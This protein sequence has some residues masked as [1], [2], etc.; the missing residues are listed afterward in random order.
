MKLH[1][2]PFL[3]REK[4]S[5]L[6]MPRV[7]QFDD[8]LRDNGRSLAMRRKVI[9]K[10]KTLLTFAQGRGLVAQ[11]VAREVKVRS[12]E[13]NQTTGP[14]RKGVDFPSRGELKTL[15]GAAPGRWRPF[16]LCAAFT[17]MRASELRGLPWSNVD[18]D[19]GLIHIRQRADAWG[20]IGKPKSKA[21]NR[22]IP[23]APML[24]NALRQWRD[25]CPVGQHGLVFPN[26]EGNVE[27]HSNVVHRFWHPLQVKNGV[28][29]ETGAVDDS[30]QPVRAAKYGFHAVR[31]AAACL[32]IG[33]LKW[34]PKRVQ[35]VLGHSSITMTYDR[36]GH[37]FDDRDGDRE[38]M[39][40]LE[41]SIVA[42]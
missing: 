4:L 38:A 33:H 23:L 36:Y 8:Q 40:A 35:A 41:A 26:T 11:N 9:T 1:V 14:V 10:L 32:F 13:R 5:S 27:S 18:L 31:H 19:D 21:G 7:H 30:G 29:V 39:K 15:M 17:G 28:A 2:Q 24:V 3:G 16:L 37:L 42:A 25:E 22:D 20:K 34:T 12:D 6:T